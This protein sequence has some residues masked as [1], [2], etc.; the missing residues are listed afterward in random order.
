MDNLYIGKRVG[1]LTLLEYIPGRPGKWKCQCDCGNTTV[2]RTVH[3]KKGVTNSCGCLKYKGTKTPQYKKLVDAKADL[4]G[5]KFTNLTVLKEIKSDPVLGRMYECKCDC[6]NIIAASGTHLRWNQKKS[7]G[8]RTNSSLVGKKFGHL[9]ALEKTNK[10]YYGYVVWKCKCDCGNITY[11]P[12]HNL[13]YNKN[14]ISCG[15]VLKA[16]KDS[17]GDSHSKHNKFIKNRKSYNVSDEKGNKFLIDLEDKDKI[18][19]YYWTTRKSSTAFSAYDKVAF[20]K[21]KI[22]SYIPLWR[23]ILN[24]KNKSHTIKFKNGNKADYRKANLEVCK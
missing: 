16:N 23:V 7:C 5:I 12:M 6:G 17:W 22:S 2:V 1:K 11:V 15:C 14:T 20:K 21:T 19:N 8:C 9:T 3:L 24:D 13:T 4:I 10:R 18:K